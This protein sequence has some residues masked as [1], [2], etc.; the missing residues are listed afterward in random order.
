MSKS[1]N[2]SFLLSS[3][4]IIAWRKLADWDNR[5]GR[6]MEDGVLSS[7]IKPHAEIQ[8]TLY[9]S[10]SNPD[11]PL[12]MWKQQQ[13]HPLFQYIFHKGLIKT[14]LGK[15][16][17]MEEQIHGIVFTIFLII[18][19]YKFGSP[20]SGKTNTFTG[21]F[22]TFTNFHFFIKNENLRKNKNPTIGP[23]YA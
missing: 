20:N 12:H 18:L 21:T 10:L 15:A 4:S 22:S 11:N 5:W 14:P 1:Y 2:N 23:A 8:Q 9:M 13:H 6:M 17:W 19:P 16:G 7:S 3:H